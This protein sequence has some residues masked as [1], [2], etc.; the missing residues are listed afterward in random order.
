MRKI[1]RQGSHKCP[2]CGQYE[3]PFWDSYDICDV[4]GWEDDLYINDEGKE[5]TGANHMSPRVARVLWKHGKTLYDYDS[6]NYTEADLDYR[7][8]IKGDFVD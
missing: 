6:G 5:D 2:I 4:C 1:P 7:K 8:V 3:F